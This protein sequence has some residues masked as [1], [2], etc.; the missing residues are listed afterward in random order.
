MVRISDLVDAAYFY[1][2][3]ALKKLNWLAVRR[4]SMHELCALV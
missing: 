4:K 1:Y 3:L 2:L